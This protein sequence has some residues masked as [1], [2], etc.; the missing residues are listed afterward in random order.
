MI[1]VEEQIDALFDYL[2][3]FPTEKRL[4]AAK[5]W[6]HSKD[7]SPIDLKLLKKCYVEQ[8]HEQLPTPE[9]LFPTMPPKKLVF[10]KDAEEMFGEELL[11]LEQAFKTICPTGTLY[12][13]Y[14]SPAGTIETRL[15]RNFKDFLYG[16][17]AFPAIME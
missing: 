9:M 5:E 15:S 10:K 11:S 17:F 2:N 4:H 1:N 14:A 6:L 7:F 3:K 8:Y 16:A 13:D 12:N